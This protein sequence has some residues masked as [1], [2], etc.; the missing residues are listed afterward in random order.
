MADKWQ[1]ADTA[2][3]R[4]VIDTVQTEQEHRVQ[5]VCMGGTGVGTIPGSQG[6][7]ANAGKERAVATVLS[8]TFQTF[9][10]NINGKPPVLLTPP[11]LSSCFD[12]VWCLDVQG[13]GGRREETLRM[14]AGGPQR[15][16]TEIGPSKHRFSQLVN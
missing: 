4:Q 2:G 3:D 12:Q 15:M 11:G 9:S 6:E 5:K 10:G 13:G 8:R 1:A 7:G 14:V 16:S